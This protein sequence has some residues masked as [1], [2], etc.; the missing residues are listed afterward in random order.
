MELKLIKSKKATGKRVESARDVYN[1]MQE[2]AMA[3]REYLWVL[4][5]NTKYDVIEKELVPLGT[6]DRTLATPREV[7]KSAI[8]NSAHAVILVHNHPAGYPDPSPEDEVFFHNFGMAG[9][10]IGIRVLDNII[11]GRYGCYSFCEHVLGQENYF[12]QKTLFIEQEAVC[13]RCGQWVKNDEAAE[14]EGLI[15]CPYCWK[16]CF[17]ES[18]EDWI[19]EI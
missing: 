5:L 14:M 16:V 6:L 15:Y 12:G 1:M 17:G 7:F 11:I 10:L 4:H 18:G 9:E 19:P 8:I 3:D 13:V 2:E